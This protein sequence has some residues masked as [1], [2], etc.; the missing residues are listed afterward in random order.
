MQIWKPLIHCNPLRLPPRLPPKPLLPSATNSMSNV[1]VEELESVSGSQEPPIDS[2]P[3]FTKP[4]FHEE[5]EVFMTLKIFLLFTFWPLCIS[6]INELA[7]MLCYLRSLLCTENTDSSPKQSGVSG[8]VQQ[9]PQVVNVYIASIEKRPHRYSLSEHPWRLDI[10]TH[11]SGPTLFDPLLAA[12]PPAGCLWH[13]SY[14]S[15]KLIHH[16]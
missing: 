1:E 5:A 9:R 2:L 16:C 4:L 12:L 13:F 7:W 15:I 10:Q 6:L 3:Q 14:I 11:C 8:L